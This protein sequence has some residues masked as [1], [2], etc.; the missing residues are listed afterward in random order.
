LF[1]H[2]AGDCQLCRSKTADGRAELD[3]AHERHYS[4]SYVAA[5]RRFGL[6][7]GQAYP[8]P[9]GG[10]AAPKYGRRAA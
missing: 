10:R 5:R 9:P 4:R 1:A 7:R 2:L 8:A 3:R 6:Y